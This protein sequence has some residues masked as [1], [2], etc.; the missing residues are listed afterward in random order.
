MKNQPN[1]VENKSTPIEYTSFIQ[2]LVLVSRKSREIV[3]E[4]LRKKVVETY[5]QDD[6]MTLEQFKTRVETSRFNRNLR[7]EEVSVV[8]EYRDTNPKEHV[9][10]EVRR[11]LGGRGGRGGHGMRN[12]EG[13]NPQGV[14]YPQM[15]PAQYGPPAQYY[16]M[17]EVGQF[18]APTYPNYNIQQGPQF[19]VPNY[20]VQQGAPNPRGHGRGRGRGRGNWRGQGQ[21]TPRR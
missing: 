15:Y 17:Q 9:R 1:L 3:F 20:P 8:C 18:V 7:P 12:Q 13:V 16:Q 6:P 4:P 21:R 10:R 2:T 19:Q 14:A 5:G 11:P